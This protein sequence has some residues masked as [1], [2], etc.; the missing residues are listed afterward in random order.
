[1]NRLR[2]L[3]TLQGY[4]NTPHVLSTRYTGNHTSGTSNKKVWSFSGIDN[5]NNNNDYAWSFGINDS[6][7]N[8]EK[9]KKRNMTRKSTKKDTEN[10]NMLNNL[11]IGDKVILK[12]NRKGEIKYIGDVGQQRDMVGIE[13]DSYWQSFSWCKL[14]DTNDGSFGGLRYFNAAPGRGIFVK[15]TVIMDVKKSLVGQNGKDGKKKSNSVKQ[16][17]KHD[18]WSWNFKEDDDEN[19]DKKNNKEDVKNTEMQHLRQKV[20]GLSV[21]IQKMTNLLEI[22]CANKQ[23]GNEH[24][25]ERKN[26]DEENNDTEKLLKEL[27][28]FEEHGMNG[29]NGGDVIIDKRVSNEDIMRQWF[30]KDVGLMEYYKLFIENGFNDLSVVKEIRM[31]HLKEIGIKK[32]GHRIKILQ[33]IAKLSS[34]LNL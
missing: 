21:K 16:T 29:V 31:E 6:Q 32:L 22:L 25:E 11:K 19:D 33:E 30:E 14:N 4:T 1:M 18:A 13:L 5:N 20:D 15:R 10:D 24:D 8:N 27:K 7:N 26:Q 17:Y 23:N 2:D 9:S 12:D 28:D 34:I 3:R